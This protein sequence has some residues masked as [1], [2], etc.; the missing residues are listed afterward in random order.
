LFLQ[1][2]KNGKKSKQAVSLWDIYPTLNEL[3][4]IRC[5]ERLDG[6][7]LV[8]LL[9]NPDLD[10]HRSVV[11]TQGYNKHAVRSDKWIYILCQRL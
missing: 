10:T 11:T 2:I 1:G 3:C 9:K 8:P 7:S 4:E 6:K 5:K